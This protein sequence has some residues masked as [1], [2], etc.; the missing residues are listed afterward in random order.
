MKPLPLV[1]AISCGLGAIYGYWGAFTESGN[2]VYE[3]MDA[4]FPFFVMLGSLGVL[5]IMG[6]YYLVIAII[7]KKKV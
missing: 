2:R 4:F 6:L 7:G 3:E 1:L 5:L